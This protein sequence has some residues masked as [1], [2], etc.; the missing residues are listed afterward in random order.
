MAE[1]R[2]FS[3]SIVLSD[4]FLDMPATSRC[5]YFT[6]SMLADD[7]GFVNSPK[8]IMRQSGATEDDLKILLAKKF[9]LPFESGIIVIKHWRINNYLRCDRYRE[10]KYLEEKQQIEIEKN[11]AYTFKGSHAIIPTEIS[12]EI[13]PAKEKKKK[14][15]L[16]EREPVNDIERVEKIYLENYRQLFNSGIVKNEK[17]IVNW[18]ASRKLTKDCLQ[19]YGL[20]TIEEAVKKSIDNKF[21][22]NKGYALTTI[23]SA[24]V[25]A[26]LIN[27][28]SGR[29]DNDTVEKMEVDF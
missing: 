20:E 8:A 19:K 12:T 17:P 7:D 15:P 26:Q 2:M 25:L 9:V 21:V 14:I 16:L 1:K 23:L 24:G 13:N 18:T 27:S 6:L 11:G 3:K 29:I 5:L 22:V 28:T 4:A 10:T